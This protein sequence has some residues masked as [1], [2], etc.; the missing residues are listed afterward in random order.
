[1]R[2]TGTSLFSILLNPSKKPLVQFNK[3]N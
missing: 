2:A 3:K 1:L